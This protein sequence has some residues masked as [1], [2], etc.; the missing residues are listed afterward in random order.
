MKKLKSFFQK[1]KTDN[2]KLEKSK[3][4]DPEYFFSIYLIFIIF[5]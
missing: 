1:K 4:I 3:T 2:S 5:L